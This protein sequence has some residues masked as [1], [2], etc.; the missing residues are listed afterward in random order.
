[1]DTDAANRAPV[2]DDAEDLFD[3]RDVH[4]VDRTYGAALRTT[5][6]ALVRGMLIGLVRT[7]GG[8]GTASLML[9]LGVVLVLISTWRHGKN[10]SGVKKGVVLMDCVSPLFVSVLGLAASISAVIQTLSQL[11]ER[12]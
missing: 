6:D 12:N 3:P 11:R 1:M 5:F 8:M 2:E 10:T 4:D 9:A 7:Q